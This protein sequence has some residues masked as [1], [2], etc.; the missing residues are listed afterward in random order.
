MGFYCFTVSVWMGHK[1]LPSTQPSPAVL[2]FPIRDCKGSGPFSSDV[3]HLAL[4]Q[5]HLFTATHNSFPLKC[6]LVLLR[7]CSR[8]S[9]WKPFWKEASPSRGPVDMATA[10][11]VNGGFSYAAGQRF[12]TV[13]WSLSGVLQAILYKFTKPGLYIGFMVPCF[14][15]FCRFLK[16]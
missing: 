4:T 5:S 1:K 14:V 6:P 7:D 2:W 11:F 8:G 13:S 9:G 10:V 16:E 12:P 15:V 3:F